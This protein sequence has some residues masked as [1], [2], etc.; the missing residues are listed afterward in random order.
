M[1]QQPIQPKQADNLGKKKAGWVMLISSIAIIIFIVVLVKGGS[2]TTDNP[3]STNATST[4]TGNVESASAQ[5]LPKT[6]TVTL[7]DSGF[8]PSS[9][10]INQGDSVKFVNDSSGKMWVAS[11]PHPTHTDYPEF[12]A[13]TAANHGDEYTFTFTKPGSWKYH[14]HLNA[15]QFGTVV[16][17]FVGSKE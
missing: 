1:N 14:N 2:E 8:S 7:T 6:V 12:I 16:V 11:A 13:K 15:S 5:L 4:S 10:T 3:N 9:I 17:E